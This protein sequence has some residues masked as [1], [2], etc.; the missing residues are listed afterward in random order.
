MPLSEPIAI[1]V[2]RAR[3]RATRALD[4]ISAL[5]RK[6]GRP[7][8]EL[9]VAY[10]QLQIAQIPICRDAESIVAEMVTDEKCVNGDASPNQPLP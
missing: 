10:H 2:V 1:A 9:V 5:C 7:T 3:D 6:A 4:E 8:E